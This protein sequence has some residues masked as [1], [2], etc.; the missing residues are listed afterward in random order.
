[1]SAKEYHKAL[2]LGT[3]MYHT[4]IL[5]G[6][7]P[8]LPVLEQRLQDVDITARE[9]LGVIDIPLERVVGTAYYGREQC[10]ARDFLPIMEEESEFA[11]KWAALCQAHIDEGIRD[12]IKAF[13]YNN[14]Y[15]VTEG[16][17]RVSVLKYFGAVSIRG[18]VQRLIPAPTDTAES[19]IYYAFLDFYRLTEINDIW[20]SSENGFSQLLKAVGKDSSTRWTAE[21]RNTFRSFYNRFSRAFAQKAE[22][23]FCITAGDALLRYLNIF[24]YNASVDKLLPVLRRELAA[25]WDEIRNLN[26]RQDIHVQLAPNERKPLFSA[27]SVRPARQVRLAFVHDSTSADSNWVYAHEIGRTDLEARMGSQIKTISLDQADTEQKAELALSDA[28]AW[29]ADLIFTTS[30]RLLSASVR[31]AL[32]NPR[33]KILNC[34][35]NTSHPSIRTYSGRMYEVKFLMGVIAGSLCESDQIGYIADCPTYGIAANINAFALGAQLVNPRAEILLTWSKALPQS[36]L[37]AP[38]HADISYVSDQDSLHPSAEMPKKVGLYRTDGQSIT[39]LALPYCHWGKLYEKIVRSYVTGSWKND[40]VQT[41]A[42]NYWWGIDSEVVDLICTRSLPA[43][44][45]RLI[46]ILK[47]QLCSKAFSPFSELLRTQSGQ[48]KD[49]RDVPPKPEELMAMDWLVSN[50]TG[51]IPETQQLLPEAQE[52][53]RIQGVRPV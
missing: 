49:Y 43:G 12:P 27:A 46:E 5:K 26:A 29:G 14:Q 45:K 13:E 52:L 37:N 7:S 32:E 17:K 48:L 36:G 9:S 18:A 6:N 38:P 15:Y 34:S 28:A 11:S 2:R 40:S 33:L 4:Q 19:R 1:M 23:D 8:Y 25:M 31:A 47:H 22:P 16:H 44:T 53:V 42:V 39:N 21:E 30:P 35:L 3:K 50:V 24:D 51:Q 41:R 10:F 20:F